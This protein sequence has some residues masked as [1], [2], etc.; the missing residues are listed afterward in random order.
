MPFRR[1]EEREQYKK[2]DWIECDLVRN[3]IKTPGLRVAFGRLTRE[4]WRTWS[5]W[6][7]S[8]LPTSGGNADG[9]SLGNARVYDRLDEIIDAAKK[10]EMSL[11]VFKPARKIRELLGNNGGKLG[12]T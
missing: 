12:P 5:P 11:C 1:L 6:D 8:E 3:S 7:T 9:F 2:F 10:N 4:N